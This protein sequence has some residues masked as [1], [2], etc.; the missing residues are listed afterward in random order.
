[1]F[2]FDDF[3]R[4][5]AYTL[6]S[7][8]VY[9]SRIARHIKSALI[10]KMYM[11]PLFLCAVLGFLNHR[12][13]NLRWV[14]V[15]S[16]HPTG[17]CAFKLLRCSLLDKMHYPKSICFMCLTISLADCS[18]RLFTSKTITAVFRRSC[19]SWTITSEYSDNAAVSIVSNAVEARETGP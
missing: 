9:M 19:C 6:L 3:G 4:A 17:N 11:T 13:C 1:M 16:S 18:L 2:P 14:D 10:R 5:I 7:L 12:N 15:N 8:D